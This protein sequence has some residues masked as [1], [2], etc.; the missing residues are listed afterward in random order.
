[1]MPPRGR[2]YVPDLRA[3]LAGVPLELIPPVDGVRQLRHSSLRVRERRCLATIAPCQS[4]MRVDVTR[5]VDSVPLCS[6]EGVREEEDGKEPH[7]KRMKYGATVIMPETAPHRRKQLASF[8]GR[9]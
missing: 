4:T 5:V 6:R 8:R 1:M 9:T 3:A 7:K 2:L